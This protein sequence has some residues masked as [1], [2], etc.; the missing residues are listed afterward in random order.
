M[1]KAY[2]LESLRF[3]PEY[4]IPKPFDHRVLLRVAPAVVE[5]AVA[6]GV[7]RVKI[8][9]LDEYRRQLETLISRRFQF[10]HSIID[11]AE[12]NPKRIVFPEGEHDKILRAA[13]VLVDRKLAHPILLARREKV[14]EKLRELDLD[15]SE[16]TIIHSESSE[17]F[18][19]YAEMLHE[20]RRRDGVTIEDAKKIMRS[21]NYFGSMMVEEGVADGLI[22]GLT[23]HYNDTIRPAL[24]ICGTLPS[25]RR[26]SGA[27][28]LMFEDRVLFLADTTVN[29]D[30]SAEELAEIALLTAD[31]ARSYGVEPR[32]AMLSFRTSAQTI[33]RRPTKYAKR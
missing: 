2:G 18:Q 11:R 3:G 17:D 20:K 9:D 16:I 22:S 29:I 13:K 19:R 7:A 33:I 28:I 26:V 15:E 5:A 27:Y 8:E 24:Q 10:M 1:L 32:V 31:F 12:H 21:R 4:L 14:A 23:Q 6:S 30:P 25:V